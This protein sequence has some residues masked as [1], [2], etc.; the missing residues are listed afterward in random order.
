[1]SFLLQCLSHTPLKG[2][3]DPLPDVVD[4]AGRVVATLRAEVEAFDPELVFLFAPDH[5]NG[6]FLDAMPQLCIGT[7]AT[8]VGDY[9]TSRARWTCRGRSPK[10]APSTWWPPTSTWPCP[11]A[12]RWTMVSPSRSKSSGGEHERSRPAA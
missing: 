12:C 8:S 6:F 7:S 1:M 10:P 11:T 9:M 5:Y 3:V 4:E 2:Y